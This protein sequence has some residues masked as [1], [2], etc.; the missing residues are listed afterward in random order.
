ML[1]ILFDVAAEHA[2]AEVD[3]LLFAPAA[4]DDEPLGQ[5]LGQDSLVHGE[6]RQAEFEL[7][8]VAVVA[9]LF[10]LRHGFQ[11]GGRVV[12]DVRGRVRV[13]PVAVGDHVRKD[14]GVAHQFLVRDARQHGDRERDL[15][16]GVEQFLVLNQRDA[17][18][19]QILALI[20]AAAID[21]AV[22]ADHQIE[23]QL[24]LGAEF[25]ERPEDEVGDRCGV[26]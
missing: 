6:L 14:P 16:E 17:A 26:L 10:G 21:G 5:N 9:D 4:F 3:G 18:V 1:K 7:V 20:D 12:L 15:R 23:R 24:E 8:G 11:P 2:A 13:P 25:G 19:V 22:D